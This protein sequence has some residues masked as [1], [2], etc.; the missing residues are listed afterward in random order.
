VIKASKT[1]PDGVRVL[2][3]QLNDRVF[4]STYAN[5]GNTSVL[6]ELIENARMS[7]NHFLRSFVQSA[8]AH[9][10]RKSR[11]SRDAPIIWHQAAKTELLKYAAKDHG[12]TEDDINGGCPLDL[13]RWPISKPLERRMASY[14]ATMLLLLR[15]TPKMTQELDQWWVGDIDR[16]AKRKTFIDERSPE[17]LY[18]AFCVLHIILSELKGKRAEARGREKSRRNTGHSKDVQSAN[19]LEYMTLDDMQGAFSEE[20]SALTKIGEHFGRML[21]DVPNAHWGATSARN[22]LK[23]Q[24][25]SDDIPNNDVAPPRHD[26]RRTSILLHSLAASTFSTP[27]ATGAICSELFDACAHISSMTDDDGVDI[28][29][30]T[31]SNFHELLRLDRSPNR[32]MFRL[33]GREAARFMGY[34]VLGG[35]EGQMYENSS[36]PIPVTNLIDAAWLSQMLFGPSFAHIAHP[37]IN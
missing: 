23:M 15:K 30:P 26:D 37:H 31:S 18:A 7:P 8:E 14:M 34:V 9:F 20:E 19:S 12:L 21:E 11:Q 17:R 4:V 10:G 5:L 36:G 32:T 28:P 13:E 33:S 29:S 3:A 35:T 2:D 22:M 16:Y 25:G 1:N 24:Y 27:P 6:N